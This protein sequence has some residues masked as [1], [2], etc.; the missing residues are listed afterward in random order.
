MRVSF[1]GYIFRGVPPFQA[2][3]DLGDNAL[4]PPLSILG[5]GVV[6]D[7]FQGVPPFQS[8]ATLGDNVYP[9]LSLGAYVIPLDWSYFAG[10]FRG[11][12]S[13]LSMSD[14]G[15]KYYPIYLLSAV[16]L[17]FLGEMVFG[18]PSFFSRVYP[19]PGCSFPGGQHTSPPCQSWVGG[20]F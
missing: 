7:F 2:V 6:L 12:A 19:L 10:V 5:G 17:I 16:V 14:L 9:T 8:L 13:L 4:P 11:I 3:A 15:G 20:L 1:P 18:F